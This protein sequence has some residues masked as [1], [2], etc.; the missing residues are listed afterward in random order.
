MTGLGLTGTLLATVGVCSS[1]PPTPP[2][3]S[4]EEESETF[5]DGLKKVRFR[6]RKLA[7]LNV[8]FVF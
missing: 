6:I 7:S 5:S 8:R 3:A 2:T 1:T 4:A